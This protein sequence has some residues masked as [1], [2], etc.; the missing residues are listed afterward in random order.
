LRK[1]FRSEAFGRRG[2]KP[3]DRV[4]EGHGLGL[5]NTGMGLS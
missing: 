3:R 2:V 1:Q 5:G 4:L